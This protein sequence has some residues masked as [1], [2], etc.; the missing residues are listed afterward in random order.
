MTTFLY[1]YSDKTDAIRQNLLHDGIIK[2]IVGFLRCSNNIDVLINATNCLILAVLGSK[3]VC[4]KVS[5]MDLVQLIMMLYTS[6]KNKMVSN[7][8]SNQSDEGI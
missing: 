5:E 7:D 2:C 6:M 1:P 3:E 8:H 4:Y